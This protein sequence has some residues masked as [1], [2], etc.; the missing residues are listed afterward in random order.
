[1][2]CSRSDE[3]PIGPFLPNFLPPFLP[4]LLT[5]GLY[6]LYAFWVQDIQGDGPM[7]DRGMVA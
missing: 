7:D 1:M 2:E 4:I 6:I 3:C 5:H